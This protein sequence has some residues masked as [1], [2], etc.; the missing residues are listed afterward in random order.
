MR[1]QSFYVLGKD[2]QNLLPI[3]EFTL[4][5]ARE[6]LKIYNYKEIKIFKVDVE[7]VG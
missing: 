2:I 6:S 3:F 4:D 1:L 7:E 5:E